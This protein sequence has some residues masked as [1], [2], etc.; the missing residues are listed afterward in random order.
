MITYPELE[1]AIRRKDD[2]SYAVDWRSIQAGGETENRSKTPAVL[3]LDFKQLSRSPLDPPTAYASLLTDSFFQDQ[4]LKNALRDARTNSQGQNAALRVR[5]FIDYGAPELHG[6]YWELLQEPENHAP[7]FNGEQ[8]LF[9]RYLSSSD[10]RPVTLRAK[11]DLKAL[12]VIANPTD[13]P[14]DPYGLAPVNVEAELQRAQE[15]LQGI[16][17][18]LLASPKTATLNNLLGK[19]RTGYDILYLVC[20]GSLDSETPSL[21]LEDEAGKV[22]AVPVNDG[23]A[24]ENQV[25]LVNEIRGLVNRPRLIVLASCESA[26]KG[27]GD[28]SLMLAALGPRLAESGVPAVLAMQGKISMEAV[29]KFMPAFFKALLQDGQ[30]DHAMAIARGEVARL[31]RPD[32]WQPVLF[33]RLR[34]GRIWYVPGFGSEQEEFE[35]WPALLSKIYRNPSDL[36]S[37]CRCTP[38]LGSGLTEGL[39]GSAR[40][41]ARRWAEDSNFPLAASEQEDLPNVAQYLA[42]TQDPEFVRDKLRQYLW[43]QIH[44]CYPDSPPN[45]NLDQL[46]DFM[47]ARRRKDDPTEPHR[48]LA[49]LPFRIYIT[50]NPDSLLESALKEAGKD[51]V[52]RICPWN[53]ELEE[54]SDLCELPAGYDPDAARPLVYHLFGQMR[55]SEDEPESVVLTEDDYFD[56]LIGATRNKELIPNVVREA[57]ANT[58]LLFLGFQLDDWN[59]RILF[60]SIMS[61]EGGKRRDRT[62]KA[63][64]AVQVDLEQGRFVNPERARRY[65]EKYF[66]DS[67]IS[68]YWGNSQDFVNE[69]YKRSQTASATAVGA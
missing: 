63:N 60:R 10:W 45:A 69:L 57:L 16:E 18:T 59:F 13:D 30:I 8:I 38:I 51:P 2:T 34:T 28:S 17:I 21:Y 67:E 47:G 37:R 56:Y 64:V 52:S 61:Q 39:L 23:N 44:E 68:I 65:L 6:I 5:L 14:K 15:S 35:K 26:G 33:M 25:N 43:R 48:V 1:F 31:E 12:V 20:H 42:A 9:S 3:K 19:L 22:A 4:G 66:G 40:D 55:K 54:N 27:S 32:Y 11:S 46:F 24:G 50:T 7:L 41:I 53:S 36:D 62:R 49:G 58:A 29:A